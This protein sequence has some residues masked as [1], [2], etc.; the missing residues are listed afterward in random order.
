[1]TA[2][3]ALAACSVSTP[4]ARAPI[5]LP[6]IPVEIL[7]CGYAVTIPVPGAGKKISQFQTETLWLKDRRTLR[8]CRSNH[9]A[10]V[11]FYENLRT[12]LRSPEK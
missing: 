8:D 2:L 9:E 6:A 7:E 3:L 10:T 5:E 4:S 1:M 11:R 12:E